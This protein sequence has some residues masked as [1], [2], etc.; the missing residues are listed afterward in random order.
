MRAALSGTQLLPTIKNYVDGSFNGQMIAT[1][2]ASPDLRE[3]HAESIAQLVAQNAFDGIDIDYER[4]PSTSRAH[5]ST[6]IELLASKLHASGKAL[7]VTV[8]AKTSDG[9]AQDWAAIGA[10]ADSV[11]IMA[12]DY[13]WSTSAAGPIAPLDWLDSVVAYAR[14]TIP[15]EKVIVGLPWYGYDW[16]A[17]RGDSVTFA[18]AMSRAQSAGASVGRDANGEAT[19]TYGSRTVYFQDAASYRRKVEA[20]LAKHPDIGGFAHWR[21]GAEDPATWDVVAELHTSGASPIGPPAKDFAIDGPGEIS[22]SAG[23]KAT[24]QFGYIA[25]NGFNAPVTLTARTLESFTAPLTVDG[26]SLT[27]AIPANTAPGL[28]RVLVTL[29][30]G[31]VSHDH[32]LLVRVSAAKFTKHRA[33]R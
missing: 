8:Q 24:A 17:Q 26:T 14:R 30:G 3:K 25:I 12:Y 5:F 31:A 4:V 28:Y 33:V 18:E 9:G 6:F 15:A 1:I 22:V 16:L 32:L 27:V 20:I 11:K 23:T 21:V 29:S 10:A 13:H 2:I 7:S 19:F